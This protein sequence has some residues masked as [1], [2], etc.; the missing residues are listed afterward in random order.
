M[1]NQS[2]TD[3]VFCFDAETGAIVWKQSYPCPTDPHYYE[4]GP[5]ATPTI[6]DGRVFTLSK[7][8]DLFCYAAADG[9]VV[10]SKNIARELGLEFPIWGFASSA[11]AQGKMLLLNVGS[12]G[13]ALDKATGKILW[14][15]GTNASG[16][17]TPVPYSL[18]HPSIAVMTKDG[19]ADVGV[20]DGRPLWQYH[21]KTD[22]GVNAA[23]P[24]LEGNEIFISSASAHGDALLR[25]AND[26]PTVVWKNAN[27]RNQLNSS[28]LIDGFL[29]GVDGTAGPSPSANLTC[30]DWKSGSVKWTF[31]D[32]GG[33]SLM[34]ADHKIIALS[35]KGELF[36]AIASPTSFTPI[37]R[38]QVLGGRCW[39]VPVLAN[40]RIF[41][42]NAKGDLVCL[43]VKRE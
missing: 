10:W 4:G 16:Y 38:A 29:Y 37:S 41:C 8:G 42:R 30:V 9:K 7:K 23:D 13:T 43:D 32:V 15:T 5:S 26:N 36:T 17:S 12:Y 35:D 19:V 27:L 31:A 28:I 1:G 22:Y 6:D 25:I 33:G 20:S 34:V 2:D 11:L 14:T 18:G 21:W 3:S 39:T 24:V 40:G